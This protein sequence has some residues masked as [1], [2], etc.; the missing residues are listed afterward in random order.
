ME[1]LR[2]LFQMLLLVTLFKFIFEL[3]DK[4]AQLSLE[5]GLWELFFTFLFGFFEIESIPVGWWHDHRLT[6]GIDMVLH[7]LQVLWKSFLVVACLALLASLAEG[8]GAEVVVE[9]F[10]AFPAT[11]WELDHLTVSNSL[12][13]LVEST[14]GASDILTLVVGFATSA[15][16]VTWSLNSVRKLNVSVKC[17]NRLGDYWVKRLCKLI[18]D[19]EGVSEDHLAL[20]LVR[21][22]TLEVV[23]EACLRDIEGWAP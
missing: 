11:W 20:L 19:L 4:V 10:A 9:A 8:A 14:R 18:L 3:V 21:L 22:R 2:F 15:S 7:L 5:S 17:L 13:L 1:L 16:P 6:C 12:I 23:L